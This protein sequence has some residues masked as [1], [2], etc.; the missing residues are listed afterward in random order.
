MTVGLLSFVSSRGGSSSNNSRTNINVPP[1]NIWINIAK[2]FLWGG[3]WGPGPDPA[4]SSPDGYPLTSP[5]SSW[6][7]NPAMPQGY[8][9][10]LIWKWS[11]IGTMNMIGQS[12]LVS[13]CPAN[14]ID[15]LGAA[16][17]GAIS[18]NIQLGGYAGNPSVP[19]SPRIVFQFGWAIQSIS[20]G[21]SNGLGGNY[22]RINIV[23]AGY[24]SGG[25][26][27]MQVLIAGANSNT[28]ANSGTPWQVIPNDAQS[29]DLA[30]STFSSAQAAAGGTAVYSAANL[31]MK[32]TAGGSFGSG[33]TQMSNLVICAAAN[34]TAVAG[35]AMTDPVLIGQFNYL[36]SNGSGGWLRFM[37]LVGVQG[38]YESDFALRWP[39]TFLYYPGPGGAATRFIPNYYA[40]AITNT[41]DAFVCN[42]PP[43]STWNGS[44]YI[45]GAIVQGNLGAANAT[46]N[47]TLAIKVGGVT[48]AAKPI[49][50][51]YIR[52]MFVSFSAPPPTAG[53]V[54]Q[55]SFSAPWLNGG[56]AYTL[57]YTVSGGATGMVA[58]TGPNQ[59]TISG[60]SGTLA[61]GQ[62]LNPVSGSFQNPMTITSTGS[63]GGGNGV[64]TV[65]NTTN[66]GGPPVQ[67]QVYTDLGSLDNFNYNIQT[68]INGNAVLN[69]ANG[70]SAVQ[71]TNSGGIL[72][73][74]PTAQAGRLAVSYVAGPAICSIH[75]IL[76]A[77][78]PSSIPAGNNSFVYN[79]LMDG[80]VW[81]GANTGIL[82]CVPIEA[83]VEMC[84]LTHSNC[85][86]CW[87]ITKGSYVT[88]LTNYMAANLV[89]KFGTEV[90]NELWNSGA[91]PYNQYN[92][93][94][95]T[96][97]WSVLNGSAFLSYGGLRTAQY[98]GL[99]RTAWAS[100]GRAASDHYVLSMAQVAEDTIGN[101]TP[102][103][104]WAG[105]Q[106]DASSFPFYAS[107][108]G[109]NGSGAVPT[110]SS[111]Y[112][113]A[114]NRPVDVS[115]AIGCAPYWGSP[116]LGGQANQNFQGT[117][118]AN[119]PLLQASL[120]YANGLTAPALAALVNQFNGTTSRS[121]GYFAG[122][123]LSS[124]NT[125]P[126]SASYYSI[127][128]GFESIAAHYDNSVGPNLRYNG[129]PNLAIMH[130]EGGPTFGSGADGVNGV[131]SV[132]SNDV[133]ALAAQI[134]TLGW[135]VAAGAYTQTGTP[136]VL[137]GSYNNS[138]G[139]VTLTLNGPIKFSGGAA[140]SSARI[141]LSGPRLVVDASA[142]TVTGTVNA[143]MTLAGAS[144]PANTVIMGPHPT[145]PMT[146]YIT[147]NS[148]IVALEAMTVGDSVTVSGLT[149]TGSIASLNGTFQTLTGTS[150]STL[151][152]QAPASLTVT[153]NN[154]A[155]SVFDATAGNV[156]IATNILTLTQAW[157]YDVS[158]KNFIKTSY[159]GM[160]QSISGVNR[161]IHPGQYGYYANSWG[162]FPI[163]YTL[164]GTQYQNYD[165]IHEWNA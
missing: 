18:G 133:L 13:S 81:Q 58:M 102:L 90:G 80:W 79:Y 111:G 156:E 120:D 41:S 11:G 108:G 131:N 100:A 141:G 6:G 107:Y 126:S 158:Y 163:S 27:G 55:W 87:G 153:I 150:G 46:G 44:S 112:N 52:P 88:A 51:A 140:F 71:A 110:G 145:S 21:A 121:D 33:A 7:C 34:E 56:S 164:A 43:Q 127:F 91:S 62:G 139:A 39:T 60:L 1:G 24:N 45:D 85:W 123:V 83:I 31:A 32:L 117:L 105:T 157:K 57:G 162:L 142:G 22:I 86:Y 124:N 29:F 149:G 20:Q 25:Y 122:I 3:P 30:G 23:T 64:Y 61:A 78:D 50:D 48:K 42:D 35:G 159:Y 5:A 130:Y 37:D 151:V 106:L 19:T 160:M 65:N 40:G 84:N 12:M 69:P 137:S 26:A 118:A 103:F 93:L 113:V 74:A 92:A 47:P 73:Y 147:G 67:F 98:A 109:L 77:P 143:G 59:V 144:V 135:G 15:L 134:G 129:L 148:V 16:T 165:A 95:G 8:F 68:L 132:N 66:L 49:Y 82:Q 125:A 75:A 152:Y 161:E 4:N 54:M 63:T 115:N 38:S 154:N 136:S 146:W 9:G 72:L 119:A 104:Q 96:L 89:G 94:G 138:S 114:P 10:N 76:P 17:S 116:W 53:V 155:G 14:S 28:G 70:S 101:N 2:G 97:G 36:M 99:S 128:S